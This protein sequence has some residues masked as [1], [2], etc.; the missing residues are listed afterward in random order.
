MTDEI[1]NVYVG[2]C[3][4]VTWITNPFHSKLEKPPCYGIVA[5]HIVGCFVL[6]FT[7]RADFCIRQ[8]NDVD[9]FIEPAMTRVG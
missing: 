4:R 8:A 7:D 1:C 5:Y 9:V 2:T 6:Q 3:V